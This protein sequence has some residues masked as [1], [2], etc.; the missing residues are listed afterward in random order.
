VARGATVTVLFCDLVG[1]TALQASLGDDAAD[2]IRRE[3]FS[4][5]R[6]AVTR[7][8]GDVVKTL[9]D[10]LMAV[11]RGS[12]T[13]ALH[14]GLEMIDAAGHIA[15][16]LVLRVGISA[17]EVIFEE[18]DWFGTPVVEAARLE[19]AAEPGT[20]LAAPVVRTLVGTRGGFEFNEL[21]PLNLKGLPAPVRPICVRKAGA[22]WASPTPRDRP[23]APR[24]HDQTLSL[25][26]PSRLRLPRRRGDAAVVIALVGLAGVLIVVSIQGHV[27]SPSLSAGVTNSAV[28]YTP[29]LEP[30]P[31]PPG[32][33][34]DFAVTC[35]N[36]VVPQDRTH[37][38]GRQLRLLVTRAPAET[39]SP[40]LDPVLD[41][42]AFNGAVGTGTSSTGRLYS[43]YIGLSGRESQLTCP[44]EGTA[45]EAAL[46]R[47]PLSPQGLTEQVTAL[48][49]C[50]A[51]LVASGIDP[52]D[53]GADAMAADVRDLLQAMHVKQVN[54]TAVAYGSL[55]AF[56][57]MREYP[58]IVRS[59][60]LEDPVPPGIDP[61]FYIVANVS[62]VLQRYAALCAADPRCHVAFPNIVAQ[63][64]RDYLQFQQHPVTEDISVQSGQAPVP[65]LVDGETFA[66][67]TQAALSNAAGLPVDAAQIYAP[68]PA[69]VAHAAADGIPATEAS[70]DYSLLCKDELPGTS[71]SSQEQDRANALASPQFAGVDLY[72]R[73]DPRFCQVW[74]VQPD[75]AGDLAP[76]V[77][78]IP[79]FLYGGSLDSVFPSEWIAQIAQGLAHA[80]V[81]VLPTL[82]FQ[83]VETKSAPVCLTTLELGFF[84]HPMEHFDVSKCEG[85][86]PRIAFAGA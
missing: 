41:L 25:P 31:C 47:S 59:V 71:S 72:A 7:H 26:S 85:Q 49:A 18:N 43:N 12:V 73:L 1:S 70:W 57:V 9:G 22:T 77:S 86:S 5:L 16:G 24:R 84:A 68:D 63:Y 10:G 6:A 40:A 54:L 17:G 69:L 27:R 42:G 15:G 46:A 4:M 11:F 33:G 45:S 8:Q 32:T 38:K 53:F 80:V 82:T 61:D 48:A 19:S 28:G 51:R 76:I 21:P 35:D 23:A 52:N 55:V 37:P 50:R 81:V 34:G 36:L 56:A 3:L 58:G 39:S 83:S 60:A 74:N 66:W 20:V 14:C 30:V 44:E 79:T 65:V 64:Q 29:K 62:T 67:A 75:R 78:D 13:D 2:E